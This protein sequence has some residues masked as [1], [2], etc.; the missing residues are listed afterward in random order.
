MSSAL[1]AGESAQGSETFRI[2]TRRTSFSNKLFGLFAS[3]PKSLAPPQRP[4]ISHPH[5]LERRISASQSPTLIHAQPIQRKRDRREASI[6]ADETSG[7][8]AQD[9]QAR[10]ATSRPRL[11]SGTFSH[12]ARPP[13][14]S[15]PSATRAPLKSAMK[16]P[17]SARV[18]TSAAPAAK[19]GPLSAAFS[20]TR[21][22]AAPKA[23]AQH[24]RAGSVPASPTYTSS[25]HAADKRQ[26]A[27]NISLLPFPTASTHPPRDATRTSANDGSEEVPVRLP[28]KKT[29]TFA[30]KLPHESAMSLK[31]S[32]TLRNI[33]DASEHLTDLAMQIDALETRPASSST[34]KSATARARGSLTGPRRKSDPT[35]FIP[36]NSTRG[37]R[38]VPVPPKLSNSL[39]PES[40]EPV[41]QA[42]G[43]TDA[44]DHAQFRALLSRQA[45]PT[46]EAALKQE[47]FK[48]PSSSKGKGKIKT[49]TK[50]DPSTKEN[51]TMTTELLDEVLME[52]ARDQEERERSKAAQKQRLALQPGS[53]RSGVFRRFKVDIAPDARHTTIWDGKNTDIYAW[54]G[55]LQVRD[56][57]PT[58]Y[59]YPRHCIQDLWIKFHTAAEPG[60]CPVTFDPPPAQSPSQS[61]PSKYE[62]ETTYSGH[63]FSVSSVPSKSGIP[64]LDAARGIAVEQEYKLLPGDPDGPCTWV[65]RFWVPVP[66]HLFARAEHRTFV[67]RAR[68]TVKDWDTPRAEVPAGCTAVGIER[69]RS[70]RLLPKSDARSCR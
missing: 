10:R 58:S 70:D 33:T 22:K 9:T 19:R 48:I 31:R 27:Q 8:H 43:D 29:V 53:G 64:V 7:D 68:V 12:D 63:R 18:A 41:A 23:K 25:A 45:P 16:K 4:V 32:R 30:D 59:F 39:N 14:P 55:T 60:E 50:V 52:I 21:A 38:P 5:P 51:R 61:S 65:V 66:L 11:D 44:R 67:C 20:H 17:P 13:L 1:C 28:Q 15:H 2:R 26:T 34:A 35:V 47:P 46:P 56:A 24:N 69:L 57:K 3:K 54:S 42:N 6:D 37:R 49:A 62:W 36:P 40:T